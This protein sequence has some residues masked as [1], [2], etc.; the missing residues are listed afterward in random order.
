[1][2][3]E[4]SHSHAESWVDACVSSP[5]YHQTKRGPRDRR[6]WTAI[7]YLMVTFYCPH[8][9]KCIICYHLGK[10]KKKKQQQPPLNAENN[11]RMM[12]AMFFCD[13]R[14]LVC[15]GGLWVGGMRVTPVSHTLIKLL[16]KLTLSLLSSWFYSPPLSHLLL[17]LSS[18]TVTLPLFPL[19]SSVSPCCV[20]S[21]DPP[22]L[23]S[24]SLSLCPTWLTHS[25]YHCSRWCCVCIRPG[26]LATPSLSLPVSLS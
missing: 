5:G 6:D 1:M 15:G 16:V 8:G 12:F 10:K 9:N 3:G 23:I 7:A 11:L 19:S 2:V 26:L 4:M 13:I 25:K 14:R 20:V 18:S 24:L 21:T 22:G 17:S